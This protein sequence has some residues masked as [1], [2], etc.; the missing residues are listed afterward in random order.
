MLL[1]KDTFSPTENPRY[2]DASS[3]PWKTWPRPPA[4]F[5]D[6]GYVLSF[7]LYRL[8]EHW[9]WQMRKWAADSYLDLR[10]LPGFWN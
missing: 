1:W 3:E 6:L 4:G 5:L 2:D 9:Q 10:G 7:V 8:D